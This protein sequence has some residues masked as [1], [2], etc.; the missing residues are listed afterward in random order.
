MVFSRN[1]IAE[2]TETSVSTIGE[3]DDKLAPA[4]VG[5]HAKPGTRL[6][7]T[8]LRYMDCEGQA[9]ESFWQETV[10]HHG[11]IL[12]LMQL[13]IVLQCFPALRTKNLVV[14]ERIL[15]LQRDHGAPNETI[16]DSY[17]DLGTLM[18]RLGDLDAAL[19]HLQAALDLLQE[20]DGDLPSEKTASVHVRRAAV[21]QQKGDLRSS[22]EALSTA[23]PIQKSRGEETA[24]VAATI[25][26][27]GALSYMMGDW[28]NAIDFYQRSLEIHLKLHGSEHAD[29]AGSYHNLATALKHAGDIRKA[30]EMERIALN[31]RTNL[32]GT[33]HPDAAASHCSLAHLLSEMGELDGALEHYQ[34][35]LDIQESVHGKLH[36]ITASINNNMGAVLYQKGDFSSAVSRYRQGMEI[37]QRSLPSGSP[38]ASNFQQFLD[39]AMTLNNVG[40]ALQHLGKYDDALS[41]HGQAK[42]IMTQL[43]GSPDHPHLASTTAS[44]GN[45]YKR[46]GKLD[47]ALAEYRRAHA[48]LLLQEDP[49]GGEMASAYQ[50]PDVASSHN[51]IG[52]ILAHQG[53]FEAALAEYRAARSIFAALL[54]PRHPHTASCHYNVALVLLEQGKNEEAEKEL[55]MARDSWMETLGPNHPQTG[56]AIDALKDLDN[57]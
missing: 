15:E 30:L 25:N 21:F 31:I 14:L 1:V 16:A 52:L 37:L 11:D 17:A 43:F 41:N 49:N 6:D 8:L 10:R 40:Q 3:K 19:V 23:L 38:S 55:Q 45:A 24:T 35:A 4:D 56:M 2:D 12:D 27:L 29:T 44:I 22:F 5:D 32:A 34:A 48:M 53:Q 54:G 57:P 18:Y 42:D 20:S 13:T 39:V 46:Q 50:N 36:P 28:R 51:N 47:E 26:N 9:P 33:A 7:E